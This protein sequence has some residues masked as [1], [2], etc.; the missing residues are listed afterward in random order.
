VQGKPKGLGTFDNG[1]LRP[2]AKG[3][4]FREYPGLEADR[5]LQGITV[6]KLKK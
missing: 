5:S 6:K 2:E 4:F 3:P 1:P